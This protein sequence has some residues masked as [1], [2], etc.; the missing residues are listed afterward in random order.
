MS[1]IKNDVGLD[2]NENS[3]PT[4]PKVKIL[5]KIFLAINENICYNVNMK[6]LN[7]IQVQQRP[8]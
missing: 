3:S 4:V 8:T 5:R 6:K 2:A 7:N 1:I